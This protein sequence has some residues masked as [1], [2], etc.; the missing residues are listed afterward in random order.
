MLVCTYFQPQEGYTP[1]RDMASTIAGEVMQINLTVK[2]IFSIHHCF[3]VSDPTH[4]NL[5]PHSDQS[6]RKLPEVDL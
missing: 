5:I 2:A 4:L 3:S 6:L 1:Q